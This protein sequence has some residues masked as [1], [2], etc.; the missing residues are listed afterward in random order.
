MQ[1][2]AGPPRARCLGAKRIQY[3]YIKHSYRK[4]FNTLCPW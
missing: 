4:L 2:T 1:H 3:N